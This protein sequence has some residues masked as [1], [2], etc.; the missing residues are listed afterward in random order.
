MFFEAK[1]R[2][3][4]S[5]GKSLPNQQRFLHR[6]RKA[7][8][9][10]VD[11]VIEGG[12]IKDLA[13]DTSKEIKVG[14][15]SSTHEPTFRHGPGGV[16]ERIFPGNEE[17][18]PGDTIKRPKGGGGS[19]SG[20]GNA[21]N[22]GEGED[23]FIFHL[24]QQDFLDLMFDGCELPN[25]VRKDSASEE[26]FERHRAGISSNG[27]QAKMDLVRSKKRATARRQAFILPKKRKLR[28]LKDELNETE[29][30]LENPQEKDISDLL[31][32]KEA[33]KEEIKV[34]QRKI[35][36]VPML[37]DFDLQYRVH[38]DVPVPITQ[39][40]MFCLMDVSGSMDEATKGLAKR[41]FILLFLFLNKSY[42]HVEM[43]FIRH[44]TS[45]KEVDEEEFFYSRETGGTNV[46]SALIMMKEIMDKRYPVSQ[47][48][49]Y[50]AQASDGDNWQGDSP[51]CFDIL[52][53]EIMQKVQH[54]SYVEIT[55]R[56]H[57][58]LWETYLHIERLFPKLFAMKQIKE[59]NDIFPVFQE[60]FGVRKKEVSYG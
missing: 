13:S 27:P 2:R 19:G 42:E 58:D 60:L 12:T 14:E 51:I 30:G 33:I 46:S 40:V 8:R 17:Y 53:E 15:G 50:G 7:I 3:T 43:V 29:K 6:H 35:D 55:P 26:V 28:E 4:L 10:A 47:Y 24:S 52:S 9:E 31:K 25:I 37:D 18:V 39:A 41:F 38:E 32:R 22:S 44:H 54:F 34:V 11:K 23:D 57:Q 45:A 56:D 1:D 20:G 21:S 36:A 16:T 5:K 49:I 59:V 48:N